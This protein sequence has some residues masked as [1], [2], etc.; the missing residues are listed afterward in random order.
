MTI[1]FAKVCSAYCVSEFTQ[2]IRSAREGLDVELIFILYNRTVA[3]QG[4]TNAFEG[5]TAEAFAS[6]YRAFS[7]KFYH[8]SSVYIHRQRTEDFDL[9]HEIF[10]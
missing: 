5:R 8:F 4:S 2:V 1:T 3:L 9:M 10:I 6:N 7:G